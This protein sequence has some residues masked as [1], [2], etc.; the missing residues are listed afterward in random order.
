M[1]RAYGL[2]SG[3]ATRIRTPVI[4]RRASRPALDTIEGAMA[5]FNPFLPSFL[6]NPYSA[7][8]ALRASEPVHFSPTLQAWVLTSY[9]DCER[10]LRDASSFSN[11]P[12]NVGGQI[13]QAIQAQRRTMPL[14]LVPTVL[15][16]DAPVHTRLRGIVSRAFTPRMI[17]GL[18]GH[19]EE[20][21][22]S[23]LDPLPDGEAFDLVETLTQPLPVIVIAEL[24]GV[25]PEDRALF[26][27]WSN[28]VATTTNLFPTPDVMAAAREASAELIAYLTRF[29]EERQRE[30]REDLITAL[31]Q[32]EADGSRLSRDELLAFCIVLL[33]AGHET[34]T[35]LIGNGLR[36][37]LEAP[38]QLEA[39]RADPSLVPAAVEEMLR[40]DGPVQAL[41]RVTMGETAFGNVTVE[42]G[43]VLL[44]LIAAANHD[45]ARFPD[46]E[47]FD[48]HRD[49]GGH[50]AFGLG[51]HFCL[52]APLAR[53]EAR[54][55]FETLLER[56]PKL[57][58][59]EA[60]ERGGTFVL[61]GLR[62]MALVGGT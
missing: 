56:F 26:R 21:A 62:R 2:P 60:P 12:L 22:H 42:K 49:A 54:V 31:V 16:S 29:I 35:H 25:P 57:A 27:R 58:P 19:I 28:A 59:A 5:I 48:I 4:S 7:Y 41:V 32:A 45:P 14:G 23:L 47:R 46:P 55:A 53:L 44:V 61:R 50:L 13:A 24:L 11:S 34:T 9:A 51:P 36:A 43:A 18:H 10:V 8:A 40:Y 38:E 20:I 6:A 17:E 33:V 39:L 1:H 30:P 3:A 15:N 52:G 37:L